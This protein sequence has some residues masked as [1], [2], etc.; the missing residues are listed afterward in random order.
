MSTFNVVITGRKSR[1]CVRDPKT[2]KMV[3]AD[4]IT[5]QVM[6]Y[7]DARHA[8]QD[9]HRLEGL[10]QANPG[11]VAEV[12]PSELPVEEPGTKMSL[13]EWI[14]GCAESPLPP[15]SAG[16][17]EKEKFISE[18]DRLLAEQALPTIEPQEIAAH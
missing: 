2:N 4:D 13:S 3:I 7:R 5:P 1:V 15:V 17:P 16:R 10:L 18:I 12:R 9:A 6:Q 8:F 14:K 11:A